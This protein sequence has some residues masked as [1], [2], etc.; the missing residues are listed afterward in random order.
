MHE[1]ETWGAWCGNDQRIWNWRCIPEVVIQL[2]L[3]SGWNGSLESSRSDDGDMWLP[4]HS[5]TITSN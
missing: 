3:H 1:L 4:G 5:S 2:R